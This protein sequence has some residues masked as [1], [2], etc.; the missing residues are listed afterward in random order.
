[1]ATKHAIHGWTAA[2]RQELRSD[3]IAVC[4][5]APGPVDT[6]LFQHAANYTGRGVKPIRPVI[7]VERVADAIVSLVTDGLEPTQN[8]FHATG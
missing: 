4:E 8:R 5:V 1:V 7:D 3:R 2:L 6:P